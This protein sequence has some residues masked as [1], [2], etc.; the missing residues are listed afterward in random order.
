MKTRS[1][2]DPVRRRRG[3]VGI[4]VVSAVIALPTT[5]RSQG[6]E[7]SRLEGTVRD[8][9]RAA[10]VAARVT[11]DGPALLG[12]PRQTMTDE[13]G[14]YRFGLLMPGEYRIAVE[15]KDMAR[16]E[17]TDVVLA[18]ATTLVADFTLDVAAVS[19]FVSV[20]SPSPMVDVRSP[21]VVTN[22][23]SATLLMLP[24]RPALAE[25]LTLAPG[26]VNPT[27]VPGLVVAH[28]G[29]LASNAFAV[30]GVDV[31]EPRRQ[32]MHLAVSHNWLDQVQVLVAGAG[33]DY[34]DFTGAVGVAV[35]RTGA[36]QLSG[37]GGF[38]T[39]RFSWIDRNGPSLAGKEILSLWETGGQ[40]GGA[41]VPDR[42]WFFTGAEI[43]RRADRPLGYTG[44]PFSSN[45]SGRSIAKLTAAPW[46]GARLEGHVHWN[47]VQVD[48]ANAGPF[49]SVTA[50]SQLRRADWSWNVRF[51]KPIGAHG[52]I[53][54]RSGG[55]TSDSYEGPPS[56]VAL[57]G[58][59]AS[60]AL[61]TNVAA[62]NAP[63]YRMLQPAQINGIVAFSRTAPGGPG[64]HDLRAGV[65]YKWNRSIDAAGLPGA[66]RLFTAAGRP[67]RVQ[68]W[69]GD[70][71]RVAGRRL[72]L[73]MQDRWAVS[74]RLTVQGGLRVEVNEG[75]ISDGAVV[76][77][78]TPVAL[79][80]GA[81]WALGAGYGSA[82]K[83]AAGRYYDAL[84][85]QYV[86]FMDLRGLS[87]SRVFLIDAA[88]DR[89][90]LG[91][92]PPL[93]A[94]GIDPGLRH[95]HMDQYVAGYERELWR[96]TALQVHYMQRRYNDFVAVTETRLDWAPVDLTDPGPDGR[97]STA[98]DGGMFTAYRQAN[99][100]DRFLW[101][102]NPADAFRRHHGLQA[103]IRK[104]WSKSWQLQASYSW[105]RTTGTMG[106][107]E[108]T[109]AGLN[110]AGELTGTLFGGR[111]LNPNGRINA[112]GRAMYDV[113]EFKVFGGYEA[114]WYGGL[115]VSGILQHRSGNR[116][117]R[118]ITYFDTLIPNDWQTILLEPRGSR[119]TPAV[120]NLDLRVEKNIRWGRGTRIGLLGDVLNATN[121]GAALV[122]F[123]MSGPSF[124]MPLTRSEPRTL[125]AAARVTF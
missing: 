59:P 100:A 14:H 58:S 47:R 17:R 95:S 41:L 98:D 89:T 39:S 46:S 48:A 5:V 22:I 27:V 9:S 37:L 114:F 109:N 53:E 87:P 93:A 7:Q 60:I 105:S 75:T 8:A 40:L 2:N 103:I 112:G 104:R 91:G 118:R 13:R 80:G 28:G 78:T 92:T 67:V 55:Y 125:R 77:R 99:P 34:G 84:L 38:H 15:A 61:E 124:G 33:A 44:A 29:T 43:Y 81:V 35:L 74:S 65:E 121:Q 52:A 50:L 25:V 96:D 102:T 56:R 16:A 23:D 101:L 83:V 11:L 6:L 62:G 82:L 20:E 45:Y 85:T 97:L 76:L 119:S 26:I 24:F 79:R 111:F 71:T 73:Q 106:N 31:T 70:R 88:G 54:A 3:L 90:L 72:S 69:A 113:R 49:T 18:V 115:L 19:A 57:A 42:L 4:L 94:R 1:G 12:G 66:E 30:D 122:V 123:P 116:W 36:N 64:L 63:S 86:A 107:G 108:G 117:E 10:V 21:A 110:D 32:A 68:T 120:W 51:S